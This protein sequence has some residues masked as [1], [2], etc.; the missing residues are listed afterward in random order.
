MDGM[1]Y[2]VPKKS[3]G[4]GTEVFPAA[5]GLRYGSEWAILPRRL[6]RGPCST[7]GRAAEGGVPST[8]AARTRGEA[9]V[10]EVMNSIVIVHDAKRWINRDNAG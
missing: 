4:P 5:S 6:E 2:H 1:G 10:R 8:L 3:A 9:I 7:R